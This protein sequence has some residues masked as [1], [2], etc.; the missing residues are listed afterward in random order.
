MDFY[1]NAQQRSPKVERQ[2]VGGERREGET[3]AQGVTSWAGLPTGAAGMGLGMGRWDGLQGW[4]LGW[5]VG[6][7][8]WDGPPGWALEWAMGWA[9]GWATGM[10]HW[11][12]ASGMGHRDG[13]QVGLWGWATTEGGL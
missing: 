6:I 1:V 5:A 10:H 7:P 12:W 9:P 11:G 2:E 4:V 8:C 3:E 13:P